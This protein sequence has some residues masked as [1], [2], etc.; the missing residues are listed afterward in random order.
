MADIILT[1]LNGYGGNLAREL[2]KDQENTLIA[3]ISGSPEKSPYYAE[4]VK[5]GTRFFKSLDEC[6][7]KKKTDI[8]LICTPMHIH[9]KE[10]KACLEK[11]VSVYCEKPLTTTLD[12][13]LELQ[14]IAE[15]KRL[16][17][18]VGFQWTYSNGIQKLKQDL[19][20]GKY[21]KLKSIK[22]FANFVRPTSYYKESNWKGRNLDASGQVI[23]D[24]V[25][26]N[27]AAHYIH[28]ML[29]LCG[30]EM[31]KALD[32]TDAEIDMQCYRA[33]DIET[34]DTISMKIKK[35]DVQIGFW[36]TLASD[37][38]S[39]LEWEGICEYAKILYPYDAEKH[40]AVI[41]EDGTTTLYDSPDEGRFTHYQSVA[42]AIANQDKMVCSVET[43]I[44]FQ[45]VVEYLRLNLQ[46]EGFVEAELK[47]ED[48]RIMI[49]GIS[50][51]LRKAYEEEQLWKKQM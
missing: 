11:G 41:E 47:K 45:Q 28:N 12:T 43:V 9:Y 44:P 35:D 20:D 26:S 22:T 39:P 14:K 36:S 6:L 30:E 2:L 8:A 21:G 24:N 38:E 15:E 46:V 10:V 7:E 42:R 18:A 19:L 1:G 5:Q 17:I 23:F 48:D 33:H 34:F 32:V 50:E 3:V 16:S 40:I 4:L 31:E 29:F 25:V 27:A 13:A 51:G 37:H 49:K